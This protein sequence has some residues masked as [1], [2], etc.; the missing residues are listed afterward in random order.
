[1]DDNFTKLQRELHLP[2]PTNT[3][4]KSPEVNIIS[5]CVP[6]VYRYSWYSTHY[7]RPIFKLIES[8]KLI[9]EYSVD[10]K[11]SLITNFKIKLNENTSVTKIE[12]IYRESEDTSRIL[13]SWSG[14]LL[15]HYI[16]NDLEL[17]WFMT[18]K[19]QNGIMIRHLS[20]NG[21]II[22]RLEGSDVELD[23]IV[24][25]RQLSNSEQYHSIFDHAK[26]PILA[27]VWIP[28]EELHTDST[29]DS[30]LSVAIFD[31]GEE[32]NIYQEEG[33]VI[34]KAPSSFFRE[35]G[36]VLWNNWKNDHK[37][38][39]GIPLNKKIVVEGNDIWCLV[40]KNIIL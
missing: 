18:E 39:P 36:V 20:R 4:V 16:D 11:W 21:S 15:Q 33:D 9:S 40:Y 34:C 25:Y 8:P 10:N 32:L 27:K 22:F 13:Q 38:H 12:M 29:C 6:S 24:E 3:D 5:Y 35:N 37:M 26:R 30:L 2:S 14:T 1:M 31:C 23:A 28:Y 7:L 19:D 17:D